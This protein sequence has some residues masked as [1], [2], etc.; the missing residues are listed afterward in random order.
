MDYFHH[1]ELWAKPEFFEA[2]RIP[3][4]LATLDK[5]QQL[6]PK[7]T[8]YVVHHCW[9]PDIR[10][11]PFI[12]IFFKL[13]SFFKNNLYWLEYLKAFFFLF[14]QL[15]AGGIANSL[16]QS[17]TDQM[18][19]TFTNSRGQYQ[20]EFVSNSTAFRYQ[21]CKF[22]WQSKDSINCQTT[23]EQTSLKN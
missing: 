9:D 12:G 18:L 5:S 22:T 11:P 21:I 19:G 17:K 4:N 20:H 3:D 14:T 6:K 10:R 13:P 2:L 16:S 7:I 15:Q 8:V 1:S 23:C